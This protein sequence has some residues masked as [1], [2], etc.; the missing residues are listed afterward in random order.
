MNGAQN[1]P[2]LTTD[3]T[4]LLSAPQRDDG[5]SSGVVA[6]CLHV[7]RCNPTTTYRETD[8]SHSVD[9]RR[10]RRHHVVLIDDTYSA[11]VG[12]ATSSSSSSSSSSPPPL[13]IGS[14]VSNPFDDDISGYDVVISDGLA[15]RKALLSPSLH[16]LVHSGALCE[17]SIL[18][19]LT[20]P[21]PL[22]R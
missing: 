18:K 1:V 8:P 14:P 22:P 3:G 12:Q 9:R 11:A 10:C 4:A 7:Y 15:L 17:G 19:V 21:S 20:E 6:Q 2:P 16:R 5:P 13:P